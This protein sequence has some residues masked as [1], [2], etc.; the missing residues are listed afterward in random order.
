ME[1]NVKLERIKKSCSTGVKVTNVIFVIAVVCSIICLIIITLIAKNGEAFEEWVRRGIESGHITTE[2]SVG[3][4]SAFS[5]SVINPENM[6]SDVRAIREMLQTRPYSVIFIVYCAVGCLMLIVL[7]VVMKLIGSVFKIIREEDNPFTEKAIR[8]IVKV[9]I[10]VSIVMFFTPGSIFGILG[11][12]ITW[13]VRTILD[14][15]RMLQIQ[16]D[17]TL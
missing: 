12:V 14:Y 2:S 8:R 7:A 16:A 15:G 3:E 10:A 13:V 17:E 6:H 9:M 1:E 5:I 11:L 4:V